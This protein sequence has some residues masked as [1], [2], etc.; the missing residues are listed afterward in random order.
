MYDSEVFQ[1][2]K[3]VTRILNYLV[4]YYLRTYPKQPCGG[5]GLNKSAVFLKYPCNKV[6]TLPVL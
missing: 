5:T 3:T 1:E 2:A 6:A 4:D